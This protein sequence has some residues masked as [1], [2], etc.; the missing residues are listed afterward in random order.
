MRFPDVSA[1]AMPEKKLKF[2]SKPVSLEFISVNS[3]SSASCSSMKISGSFTLLLLLLLVIL[4]A[5]V[6]RKPV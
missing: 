1:G 5:D 3:L 4:A 2:I 6:V